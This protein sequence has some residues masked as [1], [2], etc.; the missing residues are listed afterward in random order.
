MQVIDGETG[1]VRN[2]ET[3]KPLPFLPGIPEA[4]EAS[5]T[6]DGAQRVN[7]QFDKLQIGP[8]KFGFNSKNFLD[9]TYLD[10][11]LRISRGG[12]G[13]VFILVRH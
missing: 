1:R 9:I 12:Y 11:T 4:I 10:D 6:P 5:I 3:L 7:V 2:E 13:N 8:F